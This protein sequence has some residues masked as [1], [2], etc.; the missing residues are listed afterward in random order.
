MRAYAFEDSLIDICMTSHGKR[1]Y[2]MPI[3][4]E[5][6]MSANKRPNRFFV[7]L[8]LTEKM[9]FAKAF[10]IRRLASFGINIIYGES[11]GPHCKYIHYLNSHWSRERSF[12][13]FDDD[14]I[15]RSDIFEGL[16]NEA[17]LNP[18]LN[19]C[20]R[21]QTIGLNDNEISPY[22]SWAFNN[23]KRTS[24]KNFATGVG[25][26]LVCSKFAGIVQ[27]LQKKFLDSCPQND[28]IW[29]HWISV[30]YDIPYRQCRNE[31]YTPDIIPFSQGLALHKTNRSG[32][33]DI[34]VKNTYCTKSIQVLNNATF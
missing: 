29:F 5:A 23:L 21:S 24:V 34:Q 10:F 27:K 30:F 11:L 12:A 13:V 16:V 28:D 19:I 14:A 3:A 32:Q 22:N 17:A 7:T 15:Y 8:D 20:M 2:F 6:L 25:G 1:I 9:T 26:V 31:F 4:I 33:N 18:E